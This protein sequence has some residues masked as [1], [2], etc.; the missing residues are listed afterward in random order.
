MSLKTTHEPGDAILAADMNS[1]HE[2]AILNSHNIL[3]L[4]L[5]N[6]FAAKTTP[7]NGLFFD[8]FS[9]TS[10]ADVSAT[11]VDTV[12]ADSGQEFIQITDGDTTKFDTDRP[13][14]TIFDDTNAEEKIISEV[15]P[16][17]P[18]ETNQQFVPFPSVGVNTDGNEID[19][20]ADL[21]AQTFTPSK[22]G[23]VT[24]VVMELRKRDTLSQGTHTTKV[25]IQ[26]VSGG[27]PTGTVLGTS[28][29]DTRLIDGS[30]QI[31]YT[32]TTKPEVTKD[33]QFAI[34]LVPVTVQ[35][36]KVFEVI[37]STTDG[38]T[39]GK[40]SNHECLQCKG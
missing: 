35:S 12:S 27:Q 4:Y 36:G 13:N 5:E 17:F 9:D 21:T 3:E 40:G 31:T 22:T 20:T 34:V 19:S 28:D 14:I 24:S 18:D 30:F 2:L 29:D 6:F 8:G 16:S 11:L 25:E 39:G 26:T 10:K 37:G 38:N 15:I 1:V 7:F 32:F 23:R 33:V